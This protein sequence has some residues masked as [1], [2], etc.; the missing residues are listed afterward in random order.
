[1]V[2][3]GLGVGSVPDIV[4]RLNRRIGFTE[5]PFF[6]NMK[7]NFRKI[8]IIIIFATFKGQLDEYL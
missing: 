3:L 1:M 7:L 8:I 4:K 2:W 5:P 6:F